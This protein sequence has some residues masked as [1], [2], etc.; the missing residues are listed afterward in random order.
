MC[1]GSGLG[2]DGENEGCLLMLRRVPFVLVCGCCGS[3]GALA[4]YFAVCAALGV[5]FDLARIVAVIPAI[6]GG[7]FGICLSTTES[8]RVAT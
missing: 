3:V 7:A 8:L 5:P 6:L 1:D 2:Q 4:L